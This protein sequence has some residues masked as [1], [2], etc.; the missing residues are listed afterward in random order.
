MLLGRPAEGS[1]P[2]SRACKSKVQTEVSGLATLGWE[3]LPAQKQ[4]QIGF[5]CLPAYDTG[6][7]YSHA[8]HTN[9]KQDT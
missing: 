7:R 3:A 5:D 8:E 6:S 1:C 4:A 2:E 9:G